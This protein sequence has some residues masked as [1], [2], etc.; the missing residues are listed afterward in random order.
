[1]KYMPSTRVKAVRSKPAA[2]SND[3]LA[4]AREITGSLTDVSPRANELTKSMIHAAVGEDQAA[5]IET[6]GSAAAAA[7]A[8]RAEGVNAF[9]EKRTPQFDGR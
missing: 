9:L 5:A 1:M 7:S 2:L 3:V 4:A 8:D 6:L